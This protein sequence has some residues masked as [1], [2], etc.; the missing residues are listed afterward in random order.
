MTISSKEARVTSVA[1]SVFASV[2]DPRCFE[3]LWEKQ[4]ESGLIS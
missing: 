4:T 1:A 2:F 3:V